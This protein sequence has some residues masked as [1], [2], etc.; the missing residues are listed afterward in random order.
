MPY[1]CR[2]IVLSTIITYGMYHYASDPYKVI[3]NIFCR[4]SLM[5]FAVI[6]QKSQ[7]IYIKF[8]KFAFVVFGFMLCSVLFAKVSKEKIFK[9]FFNL[10]LIIFQ[11][12]WCLLSCFHFIFA[13]V[14]QNNGFRWQRNNYLFFAS[15]QIFSV[16]SNLNPKTLIAQQVMKGIF[17]FN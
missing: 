7:K 9:R 17:E 11:I 15:N 3:Q 16:K 12:F 10:L 8:E 14:L 6:S 4:S 2:S 5:I 13:V 1:S